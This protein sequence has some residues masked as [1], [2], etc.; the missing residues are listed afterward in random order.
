MRLALAFWI[1]ILVSA[2][3]PRARDTAV[4]RMGSELHITGPITPRM[5]GE[6]ARQ[7]DRQVQTV[8]LDSDGGDE[9]SAIR[10]GLLLQARHSRIVVNRA[11]LSACAQYLFVA[12]AQKIVR[13]HSLVACH[14]NTIAAMEVPWQQYGVEY[15]PAEKRRRAAAIRLYERAGVSLDFARVCMDSAVTLCVCLDPEN[16]GKKSVLSYWEFW[17]PLSESYAQFGV[18]N[19]SGAPAREQ[20]A[21]ELAERLNLRA[22]AHP[23]SVSMAKY[24]TAMAKNCVSIGASCRARRDAS[25]P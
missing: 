23:S 25:R 3:V 10:M 2:C 7:F 18:L 24:S 21:M 14:H 13:P 22:T 11:C 6:F 4:A 9:E 17:I 12:G 1:L 8:V 5:A 19:V 16:N 15:T 20:D